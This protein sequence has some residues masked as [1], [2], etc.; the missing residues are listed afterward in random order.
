MPY[1]E[2]FNDMYLP[3]PSTTDK[4]GHKINYYVL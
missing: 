2:I 3:N 4:M 1:V